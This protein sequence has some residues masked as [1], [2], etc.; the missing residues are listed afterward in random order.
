[1]HTAHTACLHTLFGTQHV[2]CHGHY[3]GKPTALVLAEIV[4]DRE[5]PFASFEWS[6]VS[7]SCLALCR[8]L[9]IKRPEKR[10]TLR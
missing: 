6:H 10:A 3:A 8:A 7:R 5:T 9:L 2:Q 4:E 1:V